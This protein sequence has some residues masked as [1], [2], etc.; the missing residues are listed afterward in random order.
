MAGAPSPEYLHSCAVPATRVG[1]PAASTRKTPS[2][3][4][5]YTLPR[6]STASTPGPQ[7][8]SEGISSD[9]LVRG[10]CWPG[11]T[12]P[13]TLVVTYPCAWHKTGAKASA[14]RQYDDPGRMGIQDG[15]FKYNLSLPMT[16]RSS[17]KNS[18]VFGRFC[19]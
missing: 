17:V 9:G 16:G 10:E 13:V 4:V 3:T 7:I 1:T 14:A 5:T 15:T 2:L 6:A 11:V 12:P 19:R 18:T 8:S